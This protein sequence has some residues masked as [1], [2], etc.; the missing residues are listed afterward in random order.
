MGVFYKLFQTS[1][2]WAACS[3][4][5]SGEADSDTE[6]LITKLP[7][8]APQIRTWMQTLD[9]LDLVHR[10][11]DG[12]RSSP[13]NFPRPRRDP[14]LHDPPQP[15]IENRRCLPVKGLPRNFYNNNWLK[16]LPPYETSRL[17]VQ[18]PVDL[19]FPLAM[20]IR[21]VSYFLP[22]SPVLLKLPSPS[23]GRKHSLC[24]EPTTIDIVI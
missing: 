3:G 16:S 14:Q 20:V 13:G 8:R 1:I 21:A 11:Q 15:L 10:F 2:S 6:L 17:N 23:K 5:E 24:N 19:S 7:W 4:D 9:N 22:P 12:L 18:P